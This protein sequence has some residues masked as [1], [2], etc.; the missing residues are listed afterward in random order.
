M[1]GWTRR[2][3][4]RGFTYLDSDGRPLPA[5]DVA[6]IRSLAIPP[7]WEDVWICPL[8]QGHIQAVG[9]DAAGRRQ[10]LY[11]PDWRAKQD[12]LKFERV[13]AAARHLPAARRRVLAHLALQ[14]MPRERATAT[15]V[16]LLDLGYF[17]IGSDAYTEDNGSFG[18]TTLE[19]QHVR[20]RGGRIV[21]TFTGKSGIEHTVEIDDEAAMAALDRMRRRRSTSQRLLAY[22]D[23]RHWS[24]LDAAAV[25]AYLG[26]LVHGEMTAKDFRTWHATVLAALALATT[27]EPGDTKAS[28]RRAVKAAVEEVAEY[29]GNTATIAKNSYIDPRV[30]DLYESGT[31]I[32]V[33]PARYRSPDRRQAAVEKAV[34]GLL[35]P[36]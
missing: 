4:G 12:Q 20:R 3:A 17:R 15:A 28:R 2:R 26:D 25:N 35:A 16:R 5:E 23:G 7:A 18:L 14:D 8:P 34:L 27:D 19:R 32:E 24:D 1:R 31:T 21:F 30:L 29:L 11:H 13:A 33:D 10:Y 6:R 22:R 9:T 36:G